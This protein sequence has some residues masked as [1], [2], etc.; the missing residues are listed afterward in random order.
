MQTYHKEQV[1][2]NPYL[3]F[4]EALNNA[5]INVVLV[6]GGLYTFENTDHFTYAKGNRDSSADCHTLEGISISDIA[7]AH[8]NQ[9]NLNS[10]VEGIVQQIKS[11]DIFERRFSADTHWEAYMASI[12]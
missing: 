1:S 11:R 6:G 4:I 9:N 10:K 8:L 5:G 12:Q 3:I 2:L 7:V